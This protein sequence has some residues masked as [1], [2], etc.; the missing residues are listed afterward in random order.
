[1]FSTPVSLAKDCYG[2]KQHFARRLSYSAVMDKKTAR[3]ALAS[4]LKR[5]MRTTPWLNTGQ[6]IEAK[7]ANRVRQRTVS[8]MTR[9]DQKEANSPTLDNIE[10]VARAFKLEAWQLLLNEETVGPQLYGWLMR[11]DAFELGK[12]HIVQDDVSESPTENRSQ[13]HSAKGARRS[14]K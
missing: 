2:Y 3:Q 9:A 11:R 7:S 4:N 13:E 6:K 14:V 10:E 8:N 12:L 5:L 1:M